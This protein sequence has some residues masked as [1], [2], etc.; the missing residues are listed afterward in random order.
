MNNIIDGVIKRENVTYANHMKQNFK[1]FT[2]E[3]QQKTNALNN[4]LSGL[5]LSGIDESTFDHIHAN[6]KKKDE[7]AQ[8]PVNHMKKKINML[9]TLRDSTTG[10]ASPPPMKPRHSVLSPNILNRT[11]NPPTA[12]GSAPMAMANTFKAAM[13]DK[14]LEKMAA[15]TSPNDRYGRRQ[16]TMVKKPLLSPMSGRTNPL[17]DASA[18]LS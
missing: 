1:V 13:K 8:E 4:A 10:V 5:K 9:R 2:P 18:T 3:I 11:L 7:E 14:V 16:T 17:S 12:N 6:A 15:M